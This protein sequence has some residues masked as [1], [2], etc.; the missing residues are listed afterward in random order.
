MYYENELFRYDRICKLEQLDEELEV[1]NT[2][3]G[4]N[5]E[6]QRAVSSN[7]TAHN[8]SFRSDIDEPVAEWGYRRLISQN[9]KGQLRFP[10]YRFFYTT[11]SKALVKKLYMSDLKVYGYR[12]TP[13]EW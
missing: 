5:I 2:S 7:L 4:L 11:K 6:N 13:S 3:F 12:F 1:I 9:D 8:L 10:H